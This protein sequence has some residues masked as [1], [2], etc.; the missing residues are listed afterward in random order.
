[1][2]EQPKS[3]FGRTREATEIARLV[4]NAAQPLKPSVLDDR[5]AEELGADLSKAAHWYHAAAER[6]PPRERERLKSIKDTAKKRSELL[7][8]VS[9]AAPSRSTA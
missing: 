6:R 5:R 7:G 9:P 1:M 8:A 4:W 2:D 3:D